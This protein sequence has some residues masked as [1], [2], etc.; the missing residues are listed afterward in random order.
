MVLI[1]QVAAQTTAMLPH[2]QDSP[3]TP[4]VKICLPLHIEKATTCGIFNGTSQNKGLKCGI[5]YF[6]HLSDAHY[7]T[8]RYFPG[9]GSHNYGEFTAIIFL[10]KEAL[11]KC[12]NSLQIFSDSASH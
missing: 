10:M 7:Y 3:K 12:L 2:F 5:E 11:K 1:I 6:L 4:Q 8:G 9:T